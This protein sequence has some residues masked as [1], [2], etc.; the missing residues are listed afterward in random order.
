MFVISLYQFLVHISRPIRSNLAD[1]SLICQLGEGHEILMLLRRK[2]GG[3]F[4]FLQ[5]DL[6]G[7]LK[8][9]N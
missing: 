2:L 4:H 8:I 5:A 1:L 6:N 9:S 7:V 3:L